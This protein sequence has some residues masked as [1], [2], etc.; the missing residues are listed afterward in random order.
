V[1]P[2]GWNPWQVS[3][4]P[5]P[6]DRVDSKPGRGLE[7]PRALGIAGAVALPGAREDRLPCCLAGRREGWGVG[8]MSWGGWARRVVA[9]PEGRLVLAWGF[10]SGKD[11]LQGVTKLFTWHCVMHL[12]AIAMAFAGMLRADANCGLEAWNAGGGQ[13]KIG[14][15]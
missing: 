5:V 10:P 3:G 6:W 12:N 15:T 13:P 7:V 8:L 4:P 2:K 9:L 14:E 1:W 11:T